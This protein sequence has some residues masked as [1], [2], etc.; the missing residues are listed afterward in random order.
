M[1]VDSSCATVFAIDKDGVN[2]LAKGRSYPQHVSCPIAPFNMFQNGNYPAEWLR[3]VPNIAV[4]P[5]PTCQAFSQ[6]NSSPRSATRQ[7][8]CELHEEPCY[9]NWRVKGGGLRASDQRSETP[10]CDR[11]RDCLDGK[12]IL[13]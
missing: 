12:I 11:L 6:G 7:H 2:F 5:L 13:D 4:L 8:C 9:H 3:R 1:V 10:A